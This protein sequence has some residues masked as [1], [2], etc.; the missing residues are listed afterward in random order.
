MACLA[1][2]ASYPVPEPWAHSGDHGGVERVDGVIRV[3]AH[4][5]E[6]ERVL[7]P[8]AGMLESDVGLGERG[9]EEAL[10]VGRVRVGHGH[11]VELGVDVGRL[12]EDDCAG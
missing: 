8:E 10:P 11:L 5:D 2:G 7:S 9:G 4:R 12:P 1:G 6:G 3:T